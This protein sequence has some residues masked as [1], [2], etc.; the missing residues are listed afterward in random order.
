MKRYFKHISAR[1]YVLLQVFLALM[2]VTGMIVGFQYFFT[3]RN[4]DRL[5]TERF[6]TAVKEIS[7]HIHDRNRIV[8]TALYEL[9][10]DDRFIEP[11]NR[12][13]KKMIDRLHYTMR[14]YSMVYAMN[15]ANEQGDFL[16]L[17]N[18]KNHPKIQILYHAPENTRWMVIRIFS[19]GHGKWQKQIDFL[20]ESLHILRSNNLMHFLI[21]LLFYQQ[22]VFYIFCQKFLLQCKNYN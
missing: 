10:Y 14:R 17:I 20:D 8:E 3:L 21:H 12:Y 18:V 9:T 2:V 6:E 4:I 13:P 19:N 16:Q 7:I 22:I 5:I 1:T 11:M 15:Y